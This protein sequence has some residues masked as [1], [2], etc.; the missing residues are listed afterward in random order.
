VLLVGEREA[1]I[2]LAVSMMRFNSPTFRFSLSGCDSSYDMPVT[3]LNSKNRRIDGSFLPTVRANRSSMISVNI[4]SSSANWNS[5]A[6]CLSAEFSGD[7]VCSRL[8]L[9]ERT[10]SRDCR[11]VEMAADSVR[12]YVDM[13]EVEWWGCGI[14]H[15]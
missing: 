9:A 11:A 12:R 3:R 14:W 5:S 4:P 13:M 15:V 1:S 6:Q 2:L 7:V 8:A 10:L